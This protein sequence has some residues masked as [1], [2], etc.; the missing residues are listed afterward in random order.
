MQLTYSQ[1]DDMLL[2]NLDDPLLLDKKLPQKSSFARHKSIAIQPNSSI[3]NGVASSNINSGGNSKNSATK[4]GVTPQ[5]AKQSAKPSTPTTTRT[6][7]TAPVLVRHKSMPSPN[8]K[9]KYL[10]L[11]N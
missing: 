9:L 7:T 8:G 5:P 11:L 1:T 4:S 3:T 6:T 10:T 2:A